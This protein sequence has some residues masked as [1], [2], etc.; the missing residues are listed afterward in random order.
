MVGDLTGKGD[1]DAHPRGRQGPHPLRL[2]GDRRPAAA[3]HPHPRAAAGLPLEP[4]LVDQA[5]DRGSRALRPRQVD[6]GSTQSTSTCRMQIASMWARRP[7]RCPGSASAT[8]RRDEFPTIFCRKWFPWSMQSLIPFAP[9]SF[10]SSLERPR[11]PRGPGE[12][13]RRPPEHGPRPRGAL[14]ADGFSSATASRLPSRAAP[15]PIYRLA[16]RTGPSRT[17]GFLA[18]AEL[19]RRRPG[20]DEGRPRDSAGS[21]PVGPQP[22]RPPARATRPTTSSSACPRGARFRGSVHGRRL[23]LTGCPCPID[24]P[25]TPRARVRA[26]RRRRRRGPRRLRQRLAWRVRHE[27]ERRSAEAR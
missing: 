11:L 2:A 17:S 21:A 19:I 5:G 16:G 25:R 14:E 6:A 15:A 24:L 3:P 4:Q 20:R 7:P 18:M 13:G 1:L 9:G 26:R 27:P 10:A 23:V 22:S 12:G 8:H